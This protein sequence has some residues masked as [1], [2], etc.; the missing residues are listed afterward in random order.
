MAAS[1]GTAL[2]VDGVGHDSACT[3]VHVLPAWT[4][5]D[6][7][8]LGS[9]R[10]SVAYFAKHTLRLPYMLADYTSTSTDVRNLVLLL[11]RYTCHLTEC[12]MCH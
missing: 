5:T 7:G 2:T 11:I 9:Q 1:V 12:H 3:H 10:H 6:A 8:R 4:T